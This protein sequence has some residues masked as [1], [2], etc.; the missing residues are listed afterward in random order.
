[1]IYQIFKTFANGATATIGVPGGSFRHGG[2]VPFIIATTRNSS[3]F[4]GLA[5]NLNWYFAIGA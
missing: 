4:E 5:I 1:M 2:R 3:G